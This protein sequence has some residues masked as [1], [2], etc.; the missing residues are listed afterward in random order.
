E[1]KPRKGQNRIK[2]DKNRNRGEARKSLKLLQLKE[3]EK[4]KKTKKEWPKTHTPSN[5]FN[6]SSKWNTESN[7]GR[8]WR[9]SLGIGVG[10]I[11]GWLAVVMVVMMDGVIIGIG[12]GRGSI[13]D[14][15]VIKIDSIPTS[16]V[17]FSMLVTNCDDTDELSC[18]PSG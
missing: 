4:P 8:F 6:L 14:E 10:G 5:D 12:V 18:W 16:L 13:E 3:E 7:V 1:R 2:P 17:R 15:A 9:T 11:G